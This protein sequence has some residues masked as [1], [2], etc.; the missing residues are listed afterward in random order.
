MQKRFKSGI[1]FK[2]QFNV[3]GLKFRKKASLEMV[4]CLNIYY[5][6]V[7]HITTLEQTKKDK[8]VHFTI[9]SQFLTVCYMFIVFW[10]ANTPKLRYQV[11]MFSLLG[12]DEVSRWMKF[13]NSY[14]QRFSG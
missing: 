2:N 11:E 14:V 7:S 5:E 4:C 9:P 3:S 13:P 10:V 12:C 1:E 8:I 6:K